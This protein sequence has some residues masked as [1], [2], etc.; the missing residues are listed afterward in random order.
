MLHYSKHALRRMKKRGISRADVEFCLG[1][2]DTSFI[3]KE[4]YVWYVATLPR[5]KRLQIV[6]NPKNS[7]IVS[8]I[9]LG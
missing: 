6:V 2:Y 7:N 9:W 5:G 3:P 8:A 1:S 4:G